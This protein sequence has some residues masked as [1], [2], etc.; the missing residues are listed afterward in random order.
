MPIFRG[1][2]M[3]DIFKYI[4]EVVS[5]AESFGMRIL[6]NGVRL[7]GHIP[8]VAPEAYFHVIY[9]PLS[10][11][12]IEDIEEAIGRSLPSALK[13]FYNNTNGIKLFAYS[14]SIDG[15]RK[16]FD[17][18]GDDAWQPYS[19]I[20]PNTIERPHDVDHDLVFFGGYRWDGSMLCMSPH[21][22]VV[23]RLS[24]ETA[25]PLNVWSCFDEMIINEVNRLSNI[26]DSKGYKLDCNMPTTPPNNL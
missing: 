17:R 16:S 22:S 18:I 5:Q 24:R 3:I 1:A 25:I 13:L 12:D 7:I 9:P 8:H 23:Y 4:T 6:P 15:L 19:I 10:D 14:L 20:T 2:L 11:K 21:S 26:Y